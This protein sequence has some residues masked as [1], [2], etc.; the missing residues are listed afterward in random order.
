MEA[1]Y[2]KMSMLSSWTPT[3]WNPWNRVRVRVRVRAWEV[4]V[5][6]KIT[7]QVEDFLV[8]QG[9]GSRWGQG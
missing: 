3:A 6:D 2:S 8:S 4:R 9:K 7:V 1:K 5:R